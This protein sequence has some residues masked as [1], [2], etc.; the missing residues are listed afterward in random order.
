MPPAAR[1]VKLAHEIVHCTLASVD[2][3]GRHRSRVVHVVWEQ[4]TEYRLVGWLT[5]RTGTPKL[6]HL[7]AS[8][9]LSCSYWRESHDIAVAECAAAVVADPAE[10]GRVWELIAATPAPAG[11]DPATIWPD[12]PQAPGLTLV[13]LDPWLLRFARGADLAAGGTPQLA[14]L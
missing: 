10:R 12:G 11:F 8:P 14:R 5:T 9:Y 1:F 7:D 3:K 4:P 6:A 2:R 13:R